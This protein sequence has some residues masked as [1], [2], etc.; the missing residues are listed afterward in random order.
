MAPKKKI[1]LPVPKGNR[2]ARRAME[3]SATV[4]REFT[5]SLPPC[6]L[7]FILRVDRPDELELFHEL[8]IEATKDVAEELAK[9]KK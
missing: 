6:N 9:H 8:L 4:Q 1:A 7:S 5:Y 2:A 3:K